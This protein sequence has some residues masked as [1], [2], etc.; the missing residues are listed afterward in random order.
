VVTLMNL[1]YSGGWTVPV[2]MWLGAAS[3]VMARRSVPRGVRPEERAAIG[4]SAAWT[5]ATIVFFV[6]PVVL[7]NTG[8]AG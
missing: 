3:S 8:I 4:R 7:F 1:A 5:V 2:T 6:A